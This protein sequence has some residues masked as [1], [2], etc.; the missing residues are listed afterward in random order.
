MPLLL[1]TKTPEGKLKLTATIGVLILLSAGGL[2]LAE[3]M[4]PPVAPPLLSQDDTLI[5]LN[6][7]SEVAAH[8][9]TPVSEPKETFSSTLHVIGV[10]QEQ[11]RLFPPGTVALVYVKDGFRFVEVS[12][13]PGTNL[14]KE[15][16]LLGNNKEE[17]IVLNG[18]NK[19]ILVRQRRGAYCKRPEESMIG[20]C[21]ITR[22]LLFEKDG[23]VIK[24]SADGNHATDGE[25]I[26]MARSLID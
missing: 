23:V 5:R 8:T 13:R 20:V 26:K 22:S 1:R 18:N 17:K 7:L 24:I 19:G 25:I 9:K 15:R 2:R 4:N 12:F 10:Y 6:S 21:Q 16:A 3:W 11:N 14:E